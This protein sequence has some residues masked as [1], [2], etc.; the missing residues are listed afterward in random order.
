MSPSTTIWGCYPYM[1]AVMVTLE[2]QND[3]QIEES[4]IDS[5]LVLHFGGPLHIWR[6]WQQALTR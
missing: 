4:C 3:N 2:Q 1:Y 6:S 5:I